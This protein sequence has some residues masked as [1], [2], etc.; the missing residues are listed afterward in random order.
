MTC[1]YRWRVLAPVVVLDLTEISAGLFRYC[2][3]MP[4]DLARHGGR[5]QRHLAV[6]RGLLEDLLHVFGEAHA[7]H[8]VG[9][10][11]HQVLEFGQVQGTL[12]DVVDH[13]AGSTDNNLG[14]A[15]QAGELG[16]VGGAAVDGE[17]GEVIDVL[18]VRGEGLGDLERELAGRSQHQG[19]GLAGRA[20]EVVEL[21]QAGQCRYCECCSLTG[22]GLGEAHD[23]AAFE[24][25]RDGC[26]LDG[27][28]LFVADVLQGGEDA[29]VDAEVG[30]LDAFIF[31]VLSLGR[32]GSGLGLGVSLRGSLGGSLNGGRCFKVR[33]SLGEFRGGACCG[34]SGFSEVSTSTWLFSVASSVSTELF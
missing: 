31:G 29:A 26:C 3:D 7:Q 1:R 4:A 27:G 19:L 22:T 10:V 9:L 24:Q 11:Q 20:V 30:E 15:A 16:A 23:V 28:R 32:G 12:G 13:T 2:L 33:R 34:G 18:G 17:D 25:Q 5:E 21:G 14:A 8:L 6:R